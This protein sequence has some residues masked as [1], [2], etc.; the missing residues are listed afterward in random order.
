MKKIIALFLAV[1]MFAS[2]SENA[3]F[4]NSNAAEN[5][6]SEQA[7][8]MPEETPLLSLAG[9]IEFWGKY[10]ENYNV[11]IYDWANDDYFFILLRSKDG[12]DF[13]YLFWEAENEKLIDLGEYK[14]ELFLAEHIFCREGNFYMISAPDKIM[15]IEL[16]SFEISYMDANFSDE[17]SEKELERIISL[18]PTGTVAEIKDKYTLLLYDILNPEEK[19]TVDLKKAAPFG[20]MINQG[21]NWSF[22]GKYFSLFVYEEG[23]EYHQDSTYSIF[24]SEG[25]FIRNVTGGDRE[26]WDNDQVWT[27]SYN[28]AAKENYYIYSLIEPDSE[29]AAVFKYCSPLN[30]TRPRNGIYFYQKTNEDET[31]CEI[32]MVDSVNDITEPIAR[33]DFAGFSQ[34]IYPSPNG[35]FLAFIEK[36]NE[37]F[38]FKFIAS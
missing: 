2:C 16:G 18:S 24:S 23:G 33:F 38:F 32:I 15:K 1:I 37:Y 14:T 9:D 29:P 25:E 20:I 10:S 5:E 11:C 31:E 22:D 3:D 35:K 6:E 4:Q 34:I 13:R 27:W 17:Y 21:I 26:I 12:E 30:Q 8:D 7:L 28:D 36:N 19:K